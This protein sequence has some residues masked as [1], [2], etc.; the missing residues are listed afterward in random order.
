MRL[1]VWGEGQ[2]TRLPGGLGA[3]C[4][5]WRLNLVQ[6]LGSSCACLHGRIT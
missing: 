6:Y 4:L 5:V 1:C 2:G 3:E